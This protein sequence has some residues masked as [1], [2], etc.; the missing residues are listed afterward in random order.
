MHLQSNFVNNRKNCSEVLLSEKEKA[1]FKAKMKK[2]IDLENYSMRN[3][4]Y[5]KFRKQCKKAENSICHHCSYKNGTLK[6]LP[7]VPAAI[8]F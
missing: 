2:A 8:Y 5:Q 1:I 3:D 7:K 6:K 4:V